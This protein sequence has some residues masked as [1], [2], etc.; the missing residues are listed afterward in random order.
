MTLGLNKSTLHY[1]LAYYLKVYYMTIFSCT[2]PAISFSETITIEKMKQLKLKSYP[3]DNLIV[4]QLSKS[5]LFKRYYL[6]DEQDPSKTVNL[7][8]YPPRSTDKVNPFLCVNG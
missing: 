2:N 8:E 5:Y 7:N 4:Q 6:K 3:Y 1:G